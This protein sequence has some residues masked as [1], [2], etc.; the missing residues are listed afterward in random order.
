MNIALA[1]E[2]TATYSLSKYEDL[3]K[4]VE[5][6]F[7]ADRAHLYQNDIIDCIISTIVFCV[8]VATIFGADFFFLAQF[9]RH[10]YPRWYDYAR[11]GSAAFIALGM[12]ACSIAGTVIVAG[13]T[14]AL[15]GPSYEDVVAIYQHPPFQYDQWSVNI[16]WV[17][18]LW[19]A[20][21]SVFVATAFM[22]LGVAHEQKYGFPSLSSEKLNTEEKVPRKT[23]TK[24]QPI[25]AV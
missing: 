1:A 3:Q 11:R 5:A 7:I 14:A 12:L 6:W 2:C 22:F 23:H 13:N 10:T 19:I 4:H 25:E 8:F 17:V 15:S 18:L 9:P 20:T 16:A 24:E 21:V